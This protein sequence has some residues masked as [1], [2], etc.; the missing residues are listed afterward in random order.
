M[1]FEMGFARID[2]LF[3]RC[4]FCLLIRCFSLG[5]TIESEIIFF[6]VSSELVDEFFIWVLDILIN[7]LL[8]AFGEP[9]T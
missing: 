6:F 9:M 4:V 5:M 1:I 8:I 7:F 2:L 3:V